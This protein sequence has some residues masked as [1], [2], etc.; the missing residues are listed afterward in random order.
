MKSLAIDV[1]S[2]VPP[3]RQIVN[4]LLDAI[5]RGEMSPGK[6]V[7][8]I[9]ELAMATL[10]NPNTIAKAM[11]ELTL[12]GAVQPRRGSGVFVTDAGPRLARHARGTATLASLRHA[13]RAALASGHS[14]CDLQKVLLEVAGSAKGK[15][16]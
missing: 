7:P 5:A 13:V 11:R 15:I 1:R 3:F 8:S 2:G 4:G 12:L 6:R 16:S 10:V 9:R 14:P